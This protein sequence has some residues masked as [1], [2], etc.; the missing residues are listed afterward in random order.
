MYVNKVIHLRI[1]GNVKYL[2]TRVDLEDLDDSD[3]SD[4]VL[5]A[6][7]LLMVCSANREHAFRI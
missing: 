3:D 2:S 7:A 4:G 6:R 5:A 1:Y